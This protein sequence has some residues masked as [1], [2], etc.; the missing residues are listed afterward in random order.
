MNVLLSAYACMP[1]SGSEPGNGWNWATHLAERGIDVTVLTRS[2]NR[3]KIDAYRRDHPNVPIKF[4][5]V[6]VPTKLFRPGSGVHYA[7]WQ[8]FA[9]KVARR[10]DLQRRFDLVHHVTYTSIHVPTQLWRLGRPTVFGP[11]GGGQTA[12]PAML[13]YFGPSR[14]AEERR[15]LLTK[16]LRYSYLHKRWLKKMTT[17]LAANSDTLELIRAMGRTDVSLQFDNGVT[18]DYLA[19]GPRSFEREPCP[20]RLIWVGRMLPRKA[21]PMALDALAKVQHDATLT[22]VGNGMEEAEVRRMIDERGLNSRVQWAG[23]RLSVDEVRAAY[24]T[25][26]AMLFTS[27]RETSGVQ[28]LEAMA[29]GLPVIAL[30]LHGARDVV[31]EEAGIKVPVTTPSEVVCGLAAAID[32]FA[33][34]SVE[35]KD[36]MSR[37]S[38]EFARTSTWT[39]RAAKAENLYTKLVEASAT[40]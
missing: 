33:V 39:A 9:V 10:L 29:L 24:L 15:T 14:G 1:N 20:L 31:P 40:D 25:S 5:Y 2:D 28:L 18:N 12:P 32:R 36:A 22:I 35:Q 16:A 21:L 37:A 13:E 17:V 11:V 8:M 26:D 19:A 7:L 34:M 27:L 30:D 3:E 38:W 6:S 23:R 4:D